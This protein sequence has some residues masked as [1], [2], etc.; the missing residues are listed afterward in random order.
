MPYRKVFARPRMFSPCIVLTATITVKPDMC[1]TERKDY[2]TRLSDYRNSFQKWLDNRSV[3]RIVV[4][5]N[6]GYGMEEFSAA[7]RAVPGKQVEFLSFAAPEFDGARGK[8][9]GEMLCLEHAIRNSRLLAG[10]GY[11]IKVSGRY[12]LRNADKLMMH[13]NAHPYL[14]AVCNLKRN[15]TWADSRAFAASTEFLTEYFTPMRELINDSQGVCFENVL[16]R[17]VHRLMAD[18]GKW[19]ML[20]EPPIIEGIHATDN[21]RYRLNPLDLV[22]RQIVH[23]LRI[24]LLGGT[25]LV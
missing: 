12:Y 7:A 2:S 23:G 14:E 15:L 19:S 16:A 6:S 22:G 8:G 18:G 25:K 3:E 5:E 13:L 21:R 17:A 11:F 9:Y 4:V 1:L 10:S 20:P 24:R